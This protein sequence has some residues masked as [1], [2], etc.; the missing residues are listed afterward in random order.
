MRLQSREGVFVLLLLMFD[1][2]LEGIAKPASD[3]FGRND[4]V[5]IQS[6][7]ALRLFGVGGQPRRFERL[8]GHARDAQ[9]V[10]IEDRVFGHARVT[11]S[12][13]DS[14]VRLAR[15][16]HVGDCIGSKLGN[17]AGIATDAG[18]GRRERFGGETLGIDV[19]RPFAKLR[20][21]GVIQVIARQDHL[22]P[23][24]LAGRGIPQDA[25][26]SRAP[27]RKSRPGS[28]RES[29]IRTH[30]SEEGTSSRPGSGLPGFP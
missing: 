17:R 8:H 18:V 12:K 3:D 4:I 11:E 24:A 19:T 20:N 7:V 25:G 26:S 16:R 10:E 1:E 30:D 23:L 22:H 2:L 9:D 27:D 15:R 29:G 5:T 6:D 28:P 13:D 21:E 14:L